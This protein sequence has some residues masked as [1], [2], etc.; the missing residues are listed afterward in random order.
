MPEKSSKIMTVILTHSLINLDNQND[1]E[2]TRTFDPFLA[3]FQFLKKHRKLLTRKKYV[4]VLLL[5]IS[6]YLLLKHFF[7]KNSSKLSAFFQ[8]NWLNSD[9]IIPVHMSYHVIKNREIFEAVPYHC[10]MK[11]I[12]YVEMYKFHLLYFYTLSLCIFQSLR[13]L[14]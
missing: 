10:L 13:L 1:L 11:N 12:S 8:K 3:T 14:S 4:N 7:N 2:M 5:Y 9:Y 6:V